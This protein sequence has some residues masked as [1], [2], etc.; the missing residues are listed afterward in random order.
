KMSS[1][2]GTMVLYEDLKRKMLDIVEAEVKK[3]HAD[4]NEEKVKESA[5]KVALAA[6]KFSMVRRESNRAIVFD[7][8][9]A[10]SLE[11][12]TGPYLQYAYV[13]TCGIIRKAGYTH[14]ISKEY[15]FTED[16]KR[17]IKRMYSFPEIVKSAASSLSPHVLC[18][19]LLDLATELN[20]FYTTTRVLN[21]E[22][23]EERETRLAIVMCANQTLKN[24][25]HL[26]GIEAPGVM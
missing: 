7:W 25:L 10:L 8:D 26:L 19:Y 21:A 4:W 2:E 22:T 18:D 12:D 17:L 9:E 16:E 6:I 11:G 13:R 3:R 23:K 20:K 24:A 15:V 14:G 5:L 1:R